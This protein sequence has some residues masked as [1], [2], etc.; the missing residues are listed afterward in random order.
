[1]YFC[2]VIAPEADNKA[3]DPMQI[4]APVVD[5]AE[6]ATQLEVA[7][8]TIPVAAAKKISFLLVAEEPVLPHE[9]EIV[10][11]PPIVKV[12]AVCEN[13]LRLAVEPE[14]MDKLVLIVLALFNKTAPTLSIIIP[15]VPEKV[16]GHST[17]A[18]CAVVLL[19]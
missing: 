5:G 11:S 15:P 3:V 10:P 4:K 19:Y 6:G 1:L 13:V 18:L 2:P 17:P 12:R 14:V 16:V 9:P 8:F 7:T